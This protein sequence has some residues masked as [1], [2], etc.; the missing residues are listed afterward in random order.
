LFLEAG[1]VVLKAA[2]MSS[3]R[4]VLA[5]GVKSSPDRAIRENAAKTLSRKLTGPERKDDA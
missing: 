5:E 4:L 3:E 1:E 2:F